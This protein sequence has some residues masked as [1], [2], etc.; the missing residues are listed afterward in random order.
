VSDQGFKERLKTV[1][2]RFE[3][4]THQLSDPAVIG[5]S[6]MFRELSQERASL[7]RLVELAEEFLSYASRIDQA[8]EVL[9]SGG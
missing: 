9:R 5:N 4:L 3:H 2:D 6:Q 7:E 1:I 8:K